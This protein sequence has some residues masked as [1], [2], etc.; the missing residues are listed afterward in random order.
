M[1][2]EKTPATAEL[3]LTTADAPIVAVSPSLAQLLK[4]KV[5]HLDLAQFLAT[6]SAFHAALGTVPAH[7]Q[8]ASNAP[9]PVEVLAMVGK[10]LV[11]RSKWGA[12][13]GRARRVAK[14]T[15]YAQWEQEA[16]KLRQGNSMR[17]RSDSA[18]AEKIVETV[19]AS[20]AKNV[21]AVRTVR[22]VLG[23]VR[24]KTI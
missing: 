2:I 5:K 6:I 11:G 14:H 24:L 12:A 18:A 7:F 19:K 20:G 21:P 15:Q 8:G 9:V 22:R 1:N 13:G 10:I 4:G 17:Y 16:V 23:R 3:R